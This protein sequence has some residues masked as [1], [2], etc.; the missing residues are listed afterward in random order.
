LRQL[1]EQDSELQEIRTEATQALRTILDLRRELTTRR[2]A[3]L[4]TTLANNRHVR[5]E[6]VPYGDRDSAEFD[7]RQLIN[8]FAFANDIASADGKSGV[9]VVLFRGFDAAGTGDIERRLAQLRVDLAA[10]AAGGAPTL[11]LRDKRSGE[12]LRALPDETIDRIAY[13]APEDSVRVSYSRDGDGQNFRPIE[14]GSPG[15]KTAAIL[16]FLLAH[17]DEPIILDQPEDDLDNLLIY[18]LVVRQVR[19]NKLRRQIV[20]VTH[21]ANIVVN[22]DA[23]HVLVMGFPAHL[24]QTTIERAGGL[25]EEAIREQ[26]C[27]IM[28]GGRTAFEQRYRRIGQHSQSDADK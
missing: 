13:W 22:G 15:Q 25:Q 20:V 7:F 27:A 1:S 9:L 5:I 10:S 21:N 3:F 4:S 12:H 2:A 14:Q 16:A 24:G 6:V 18:D 17:G 23:E 26:I 28:E 8:T 11:Q 19:A